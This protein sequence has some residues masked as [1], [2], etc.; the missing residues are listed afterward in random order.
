MSDS[1][2]YRTIYSEIKPNGQDVM[3]KR[4]NEFMES[5]KVLDPDAEALGSKIQTC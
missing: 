2:T 5:E 4:V 3:A 1:P